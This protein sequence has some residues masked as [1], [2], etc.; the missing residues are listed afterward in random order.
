MKIDRMHAIDAVTINPHVRSI[1]KVIIVINTITAIRV[2]TVCG[3]FQN[4]YVG[5]SSKF[6]FAFFRCNAT[7]Q[8]K[9]IAIPIICLRESVL[10]TTF[11]LEKSFCTT[12]RTTSPKRPDQRTHR[13]IIIIKYLCI[14]YFYCRFLL[15]TKPCNAL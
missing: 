5:E 8:Y 4:N 10:R 14:P 13:D 15:S 1:H 7:I 3:H 12:S 6:G 9:R 2:R 11:V